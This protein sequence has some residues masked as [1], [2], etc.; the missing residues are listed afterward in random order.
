MNWG[1]SI[2]VVMACFVGFILYMAFTLMSHKVDLQ[3]ESYYA[4][5]IAFDK[6]IMANQN[7]ENLNEKPVL[8]LDNKQLYL[9]AKDSLNLNQIELHLY[10]PNN[11][12]LDRQLKANKTSDIRLKKEDLIAGAYEYKLAFILHGNPY[13]TRGKLNVNPE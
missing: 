11:S 1:K 3:S 9:T 7:F 2:I 5:E 12:A 13:Q 6:E 4:D 8:I 10:R